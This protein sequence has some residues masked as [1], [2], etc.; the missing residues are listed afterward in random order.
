MKAPKAAKAP[1]VK[2]SKEGGSKKKSNAGADGEGGKE[3]KEKPI[4]ART[5][6]KALEGKW[7]EREE[8]GVRGQPFR[9]I[10]SFYCA[11][12]AQGLRFAHGVTKCLQTAVETR[13]VQLMM[14]AAVM[15]QGA[16]RHTVNDKDI[17]A[18]N[19]L[20][21]AEQGDEDPLRKW[22]K[23]QHQQEEK[24]AK[25]AASAKATATASSSSSGDGKANEAS[26]KPAKMKA[27]RAAKRTKAVVVPGAPV[28]NETATPAVQPIVG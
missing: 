26:D 1:K 23:S 10:V 6:S 14:K 13:V 20:E 21:L 19:A 18:I 24:R 17:E 15:A 2:E 12:K 8:Y 9:K 28:A 7:S 27:V 22:Q 3:K 16:R 11:Q 4:S 5:A 25:K